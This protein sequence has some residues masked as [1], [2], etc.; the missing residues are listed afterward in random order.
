M[1]GVADDLLVAAVS[2]RMGIQY[3]EVCQKLRDGIRVRSNDD[4]A[5]EGTRS[6]EGL[7]HRSVIRMPRHGPPESRRLRKQSAN[8][9]PSVG[10]QK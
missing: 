6:P 8:F 10:N 1:E 7:R 9:F 5:G 2:L 4:S 3:A